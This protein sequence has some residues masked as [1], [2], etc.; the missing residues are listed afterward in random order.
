M[1]LTIIRL[2]DLTQQDQTDLSKIWPQQAIPTL[3]ETLSEQSQIYAARFNDRLLAALQLDVSGTQGR[4]GHLEVR[5]VTRRRG[6]GKYLLEEVMAQNTAITL[7]R[8]ANDGSA[9]RGAIAAFM[10]SCGF[11]AEVDGWVK[12]ARTGD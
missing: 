12:R 1:K 10:Q 3:V 9:E 2:K 4:I 6:V 7:W 5:E 11:R 8:V